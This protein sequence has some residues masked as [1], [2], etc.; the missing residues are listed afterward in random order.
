MMGGLMCMTLS[1]V[2]AVG[3]VGGPAAT[4]GGSGR[5]TWTGGTG[6]LDRFATFEIGG[7]TDFGFGSAAGSSER[8]DRLS[9]IN[10]TVSGFGGCA[11]GGCAA[12]GATVGAAAGAG[13]TGAT[14][15][16]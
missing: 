11:G 14:G 16:G 8:F 3:G 6:D 4:T 7:S 1:S 10:E 12:A 13:G 9:S 15:E 5:T 2:A